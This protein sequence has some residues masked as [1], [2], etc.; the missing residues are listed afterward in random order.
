MASKSLKP[1]TNQLEGLVISKVAN[2]CLIND[3]KS[4]EENYKEYMKKINSP[5]SKSKMKTYNIEEKEDDI[6]SKV[7][8]RLGKAKKK[9]QSKKKAPAKKKKASAKNKAPSKK[10]EV[11]YVPPKV[12]KIKGEALIDDSKGF[13]LQ[14]TDN[15]RSL[16]YKCDKKISKPV[17]VD[18]DKFGCE[19]L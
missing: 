10:E 9:A 5:K 14:K 19:L 12:F 1:L 13:L 2:M 7:R 17:Q 11:L 18:D 6:L 8:E 16:K 3:D 15:T 4:I